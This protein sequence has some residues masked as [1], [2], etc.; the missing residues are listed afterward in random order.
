M[1]FFPAEESDRKPRELVPA[2]T[3]EA[4]CYGVIDAGTQERKPFKGV[5]KD[6][7]RAL[8]IF[9]EFT[10]ILRQ[11]KD[12]GP[13]EPMIKNQRYVY[14]TDEKS[15]LAK[16]CAAWL[17]KS[18]ADV[19]FSS[20]FETPAS[21][22]IKHEVSEANGKTYDNMTTIAPMSEKL[23]PLMPKMYNKPMNFSI[24]LHGF[25]SP[26]F[27]ALYPWLQEVIQASPEYKSYLAGLEKGSQSPDDVPFDVPDDVP[28]DV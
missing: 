9:F 21:I 19:D 16:L 4:Y 23:V 20:L 5:P 8:F 18:V 28:F 12:D 26:E 1:S 24:Q 15:S 27:R 25:D 6:P 22:T 14:F 7:R 10:E 13:L 3:H 11:F 17:S 2:G